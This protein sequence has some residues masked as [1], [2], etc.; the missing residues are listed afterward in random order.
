MGAG[1]GHR[2]HRQPQPVDRQRIQGQGRYGRRRARPRC[3]PPSRRPWIAHPED[4]LPPRRDVRGRGGRGPGRDLR[5]VPDA[6][7]SSSDG[8]V[9]LERIKAADKRRAGRAAVRLRRGLV[10]APAGRRPAHRPRAAHGAEPLLRRRQSGADSPQHRRVAG[11][12]PALGRRHRDRLR[13]R[14]GSGRHGHRAGR[15][16]QPAAGLRAAVLVP[17]R[18]ARPDRSG[19]LHRHHHLHGAAAGR[20]LRHAGLRDRASDSSTSGRR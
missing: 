10:H 13:R 17:A 12:D 1:A 8:I 6:S 9:D 19:R 14:R 11:G 16:R 7:A 15:L 3:W 18:R 4:E 5:P 20:D 2:D